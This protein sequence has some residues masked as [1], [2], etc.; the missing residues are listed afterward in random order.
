MARRILVVA[1][2]AALLLQVP[3]QA[4]AGGPGTLAAGKA[5][6]SLVQPGTPSAT[7]LG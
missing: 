4:S 1:S 6:P 2:V 3:S 5:D 7:T